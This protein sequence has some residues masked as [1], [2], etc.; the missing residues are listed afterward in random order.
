VPDPLPGCLHE[1][2]VRA[3]HIVKEYID[4][5]SGKNGDRDSSLAAARV[6]LPEWYERWAAQMQPVLRDARVAN[7]ITTKVALL[8][9]TF[10][11]RSWF[12]LLHF[13][14]TKVFTGAA[15]SPLI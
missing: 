10:V 9:C 3:W 2:T 8:C 4:Q 7:L 14:H 15:I 12:S 1:S 6:T 5:R 11:R 13:G